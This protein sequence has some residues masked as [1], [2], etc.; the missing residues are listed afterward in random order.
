MKK[1]A[2]IYRDGITPIIVLEFRIRRLLARP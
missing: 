1:T 2:S